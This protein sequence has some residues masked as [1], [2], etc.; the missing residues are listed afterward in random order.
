M[1]DLS[2]PNQRTESGCLT[3]TLPN[4]PESFAA[5]LEQQS[6]WLRQSDGEYEQFL[7]PTAL[8]EGSISVWRSRHGI[9]LV[10]Y[11]CTLTREICLRFHTAGKRPVI[12][13]FGGSGTVSYHT[14]RQCIRQDAEDRHG[15]ILC[16]DT[17]TNEVILKAEVELSFDQI[18]VDPLSYLSMFSDASG[19]NRTRYQNILF[20]HLSEKQYFHEI[21]YSTALTSCLKKLDNERDRGIVRSLRLTGGVMEILAHC[22]YQ[23][24]R[25]SGTPRRLYLSKTDKTAIVRAR[26][27]LLNQLD[28][29]ITIEELA[30]EVCINRQKLKS[31]FKELFGTTIDRFVRRHRMKKAKRMI[32]EDRYSLREIATRVGYSNQSHFAN[33]FREQYGELP[34]DFRSKG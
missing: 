4:G 29:K 18:W 2:Y 7:L 21:D 19:A 15:L 20:E 25:E 33:R 28:R 32:E 27:L 12:V 3:L 8:G 5:A 24:K 30:R 31:G 13:S 14:D 11:R 34:K 26:T 16:D 22:I 1:T 10:Q 23:L 9:I 6:G 17:E